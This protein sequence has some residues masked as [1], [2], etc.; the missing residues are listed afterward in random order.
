MESIL[1]L[2][3]ELIMKILRCILVTV[4]FLTN[5]FVLSQD[6]KDDGTFQ[7]DTKIKIPNHLIKRSGREWEYSNYII[8]SPAFNLKKNT[9]AGQVDILT[10]GAA[11]GVTDYLSIEGRIT[12][13]LLAPLFGGFILTTKVRLINRYHVKIGVSMSNF[14]VSSFFSFDNESSTI[15][16]ATF[17]STYATLGN[18]YN[19]LTIG[20]GQFLGE[21]MPLAQISGISRLFKKTSFIFDSQLVILPVLDGTPFFYV[22]PGFRFHKKHSSLDIS[23]F[24]AGEVLDRLLVLPWVS[25][26]IN[27][28]R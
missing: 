9:F 20:I 22:I 18:P 14:F 3:I 21:D 16:H 2:D 5:L 15:N 17:L 13:L 27:L 19:N 25:W 6:R 11:Y 26:N 23:V 7:N 10:W 24:L 4:L 12:N 8:N 28:T 1:H